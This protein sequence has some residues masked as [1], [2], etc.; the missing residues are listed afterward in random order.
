MLFVGLIINL[1]KWHEYDAK[2]AVKFLFY[3]LIKTYDYDMTLQNTF[4]Q[5]WQA[6]PHLIRGKR[7]F[8]NDFMLEIFLLVI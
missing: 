1:C 5:T 3:N 2:Y 7:E 4:N 8:S 6:V